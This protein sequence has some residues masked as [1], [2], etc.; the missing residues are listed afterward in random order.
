VRLTARSSLADVAVSV[1]DALRR[2]GIRAVLTGG[3][4]AHLYSG[5]AYLSRDADF[6]LA[7]PCNRE[8]LDRALAT[9]GFKR[10]RDRYVHPV[11]PFFA[12]FPPGPLG[13]GEDV[14][15]RPVW[16]T[17]RDART[18][19]LS[20]TDACRD[21]LAAFYHWNDRQ[22]LAAAVA[23]ARRNHI[24]FAKVRGWSRSEGHLSEYV[25]FL[26]ELRRAGA[27]GRGSKRRSRSGM[28]P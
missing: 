17:R 12:E 8:D 20:P 10:S 2:A 1:G 18:L 19:A 7:A 26:A 15:I 16:K 27:R 14:R 21:R 6:V 28:K 25:A 9:V 11:V 5:G 23:I 24:A 3:A 13:I 22:S 4:C